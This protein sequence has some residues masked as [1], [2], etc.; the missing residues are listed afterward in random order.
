VRNVGEVVGVFGGLSIK[1]A[2]FWRF[3]RKTEY[4]STVNLSALGNLECAIKQLRSPAWPNQFPSIDPVKAGLG[5]SLYAQHCSECH[6]VVSRADEK[7]KYNAVMTPLDKVGTDPTMANNAA[8]HVVKTLVLKGSKQQVLVGDDF[9]N[10][11]PALDI[12]VNGVIGMVLNRPISAIRAGLKP[13]DDRCDQLIADETEADAKADKD[14]RDFDLKKRL[15][16][17]AEKRQQKADTGLKYKARP[18]NGIWATAPYL[19]NGSVPSLYELLKP[20]A[21]RID[22]FHVGNREFDPR[23]VGYRTD[24]GPSI[25]KVRKSDGEVQPGNDNAGHDYA[26][27]MTDDERWAIVEY[28]KGL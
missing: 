12:A 22:E 27:N 10:T 20:P 18:L 21:D 9:R 23:N 4:S 16:D 7:E 14:T 26:A 11:T 8:G 17:Y 25:F 13:E 19:H 5:K 28:M 24:V 15:R 2:P 3:W 6:Q 1:K